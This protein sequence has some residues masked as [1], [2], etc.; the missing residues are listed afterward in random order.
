MRIHNHRIRQYYL[1]KKKKTE[2][3]LWNIVNAN[4]SL[5]NGPPF[6]TFAAP[7]CLPLSYLYK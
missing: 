4:S 2:L 1:K 6:I 7:L 3:K 5:N